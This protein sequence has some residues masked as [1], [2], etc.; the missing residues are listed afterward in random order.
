MRCLR[1]RQGEFEVPKP[2]RESRRESAR[3]IRISCPLC[4]AVHLVFCRF[5]NAGDLV[6]RDVSLSIVR[7]KES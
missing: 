4:Q 7:S 2:L 6:R 5:D 3:N 1:C